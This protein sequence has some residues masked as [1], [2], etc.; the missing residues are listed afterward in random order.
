MAWVV[1]H[2]KCDILVPCVIRSTPSEFLCVANSYMS[3]NIIDTVNNFSWDIII[4][5]D[6]VQKI[7]HRIIVYNN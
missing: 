6:L 2:S 5:L 1:Y 4:T 3:W 7:S